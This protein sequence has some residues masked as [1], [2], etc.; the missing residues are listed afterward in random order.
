MEGGIINVCGKLC[1]QRVI[2]GERVSG[3]IERDVIDWVCIFA[4]DV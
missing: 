2:I 1:R 3:F 4:I